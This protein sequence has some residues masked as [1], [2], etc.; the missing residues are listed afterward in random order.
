MNTLEPQLEGTLK[1]SVE[2]RRAFFLGSLV[3]LTLALITFLAFLEFT[4]V[5]TGYGYDPN[6]LSDQ[7][8]EYWTENP[9][10]VRLFHVGAPPSKSDSVE[11]LKF[12]LIPK[13]KDP[14]E[15]RGFALGGSTLQ[16]FPFPVGL[17]FPSLA[18]KLLNSA[19]ANI[20]MVNLGYSAMSSDYVRITA[21]KLLQY[22]PD[23]LVIY[24]GHNEFYGTSNPFN[25]GAM[26]QRD[27]RIFL[28]QFRIFQFFFG[29]IEGSQEPP[30]GEALTLMAKQFA[31]RHYPNTPEINNKVEDF[32]SANIKSILDLY[33]SKKIPV[34]L[35]TPVSNLK[36]M[37]PFAG[38]LDKELREK[39]V[40]DSSISLTQED[41]EYF[42][43]NKAPQVLFTEGVSLSQSDLRKQLLVEA[44]DND[45]IP[46]RARSFIPSAIRRIAEDYK[47]DPVVLIDSEKQLVQLTGTD[48]RGNELFI[49]H[50]HFR[51]EGN[52]LFARILSKELAN[53]FQLNPPI[54]DYLSSLEGKSYYDFN[55]ITGNNDY[56]EMDGFQT[57]AGLIQQPPYSEML[58]PYRMNLKNLER[59]AIAKDEKLKDLLTQAPNTK[60]FFVYA[61][62]LMA[63][64]KT[65]EYL[66]LIDSAVILA[67]GS[68]MM[69][70]MK[71]RTL[72]PSDTLYANWIDRVFGPE[73]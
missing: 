70:R 54:H 58:V 44:K 1:P 22:E 13:E 3:V 31:Q 64:G 46:F 59:N 40:S 60:R 14:G 36:D 39:S 5:L 34:F 15:L 21:E 20:Q 62:Y 32:F 42:L 73:N 52:W 65:Q 51:P 2:K 43:M 24:S 10:Y 71:L 45:V 26:W 9:D 16:G 49:D 53:H 12:H 68:A 66:S 8:S 19:G 37:P 50:L 47:D 11:V 38:T 18:G 35:F 67:G 30:K 63:S 23:F 27:L 4:L 25:T 61:D 7:G 56:W 28:K 48:I 57:V 72:E 55:A 69:H 17:S 33:S 29:I 6:P 41:Y